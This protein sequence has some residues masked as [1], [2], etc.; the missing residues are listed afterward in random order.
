MPVIQSTGSATF[1]WLLYF[2]GMGIVILIISI[3]AFIQY[4]IVIK[5]FYFS[6]PVKLL[7]PML[8]FLLWIFYTPLLESFVSM[9][10]CREGVHYIVSNMEC[11]SGVH[12]AFGILSIIFSIFLFVICLFICLLYNETQPV[13]DDAFA[14][15]ENTFEVIF[16]V[17]RTGIVLFCNFI[18]NVSK[19]KALF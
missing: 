1:Y 4:S 10:R 12:I 8:L 18:N 7:R 3:I 9:F 14:R 15:S 19:Y 13:V 17:Y 2:A 6:W 16:L 5:K 11:F